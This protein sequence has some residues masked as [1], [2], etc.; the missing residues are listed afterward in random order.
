MYKN[1]K[2]INTTVLIVKYKDSK[3]ELIT[4]TNEA[5]TV[6]KVK[7]KLLKCQQQEYPS[8]NIFKLIPG[9]NILDLLRS[10][11]Q[12]F[13][14]EL[15]QSAQTLIEKVDEN[16]NKPDTVVFGNT[17]NADGPLALKTLL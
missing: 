9:D 11:D 16:V 10:P 15:K 4:K 6:V 12:I 17:Q 14:E 13:Y 8:P 2:E 5:G 7:D 1:I 3:V